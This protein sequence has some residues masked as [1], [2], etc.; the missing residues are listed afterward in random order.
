MNETLWT[1]PNKLESL[2]DAI[3]TLSSTLNH[4]L[5]IGITSVLVLNSFIGSSSEFMFGMINTLQ[6]IQHFRIIY[7]RIP[8]VYS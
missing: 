2:P 4:G 6:I 1:Y 7:L 5:T 3:Q 8:P